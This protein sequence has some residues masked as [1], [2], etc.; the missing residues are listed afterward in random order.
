MSGLETANVIPPLAHT[1]PPK[2]LF[3]DVFLEIFKASFHPTLLS[4]LFSLLFHLP[5]PPTT[6]NQETFFLGGFF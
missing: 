5:T 3:L 1:L 6:Y 2:L 4:Y